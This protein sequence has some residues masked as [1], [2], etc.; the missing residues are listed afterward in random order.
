MPTFLENGKYVTIHPAN[1]DFL[2]TAGDYDHEPVFYIKKD[3]T[4]PLGSEFGY[5]FSCLT[6]T[7]KD[8]EYKNNSVLGVVDSKV[9]YINEPKFKSL[10]VEK[11][12]IIDGDLLVKGGLQVD[13][14]FTTKYNLQAKALKILDKIEAPNIIVQSI[15]S[16]N[17]VSKE[18]EITK[19]TFVDLGGNCVSC[20]DLNVV[21]IKHPTKKYGTFENPVM[22]SKADTNCFL[23]EE[24]RCVI[25]GTFPSNNQVVEFEVDTT[26]LLEDKFITVD[27]M[28]LYGD[29]NIVEMNKCIKI[30]EPKKFK[31]VLNLACHTGNSIIKIL[32][33]C[34]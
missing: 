32:V 5:S 30:L 10:S 22:I 8:L 34:D 31:V 3:G 19:G 1:S 12:V 4:T 28:D 16:D 25:I 20:K 33:K 29:T 7:P 14:L 23:L 15:K 17:I 26:F 21:N 9:G 24:Q 27:V 13:G 18:I 11:D 6:D 2:F